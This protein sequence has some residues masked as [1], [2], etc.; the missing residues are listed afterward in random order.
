[1]NLISIFHN[2][3]LLF[4]FYLKAN[5]MGNGKSEKGKGFK[6]YISKG[7]LF[8]YALQVVCLMIITYLAFNDYF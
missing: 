8:L 7:A 1:M 5:I 4:Y 2:F 3:A 6:F